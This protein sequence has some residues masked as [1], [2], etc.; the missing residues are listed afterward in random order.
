MSE[1][2]LGCLHDS[3]FSE[4]CNKGRERAEPPLSSHEEPAELQKG[5]GGCDFP[6]PSCKKSLITCQANV[7]CLLEC[8]S[9]QVDHLLV[10][11][12]PKRSEDS[13]ENLEG[14]V[15]QSKQH[16]TQLKYYTRRHF[17]VSREKHNQP[18]LFLASEILSRMAA[19]GSFVTDLLN[20]FERRNSE[21][22]Q[23]ILQLHVCPEC[24]DRYDYKQPSPSP[25][26]C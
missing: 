24:R 11:L 1:G 13:E 12:E 18:G 5:A 4:A 10:M 16:M 2:S 25:G 17:E 20:Y 6:A 21:L 8:S 14:Y 3:V 22:V 23:Y 19:C 26:N 7:K 9:S 15:F